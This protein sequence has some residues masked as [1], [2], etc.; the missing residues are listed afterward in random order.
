MR[1]LIAGLGSIGRRHL[2]NLVSLG[3]TDI[4]LLRSQAAYPPDEDLM[5]F[6]IVTEMDAA[7]H[8]KPDAV[9]VSNPTAMHLKVAIPAAQAGCHLLL[10]K[11]IS[12]SM[13][14]VDELRSAVKSGGGNVLVGF[15][16]R[17][18]PSLLKIREIL[19]NGQIGRV[20][21][22]RSH[23]VEFLPGWHPQEDYRRGY[24]ARRD[25]GGGVVLSLCHPLDYM[26][27]LFGQVTEL[28]AITGKLSDLEIE[29]EDIA[30]I[31][32]NFHAKTIGSLHLDYIQQPPCHTLEVIGTDGS[33]RWD[34]TEG[35]VHH[36]INENQQWRQYPLRES[37]SRND[38]F[39]EE[40]R[41]FIA[42]V[43]GLQSPVCPLED[44]IYVQKMIEAVHHSSLQRCMVKMPPGGRHG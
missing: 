32:L 29:V 8:H 36:Y 44:G 12:H 17:F 16:F 10:E 15:Q 42:C 20:L 11:P 40:M 33:I 24:S 7:L 43:E 14:G 34:Y 4:I 31:I 3:E 27:W 39:M 2:R 26:H 41:H 9:I 22:C 23:W 6:P 5:A 25:L 1:F 37:F 21:F 13:Q 19:S 18:H 28:A 35:I 30:E 38:L